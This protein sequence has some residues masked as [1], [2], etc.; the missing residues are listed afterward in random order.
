MTCW[1]YIGIAATVD[2]MAIK[3]AYASQLKRY[4]PEDDPEGFKALRI[5]LEEAL[6]QAKYLHVDETLVF[7]AN[8][9]PLDENHPDKE[10][11][12]R[13][14]PQQTV[15]QLNNP[16]ANSAN[17]VFEELR[18]Q[19]VHL[20]GNFDQRIQL[21]NWQAIIGCD[22]LWDLEVKQ[23]TALWLF[24]FIG[25]YPFITGEVFDYLDAQFSWR[26]S[27]VFLKRNFHDDLIDNVFDRFSRHGWGLSYQDIHFSEPTQ[28][29]EVESYLS[30]RE[31]LEYLVINKQDENSAAL[32]E[33][34]NKNNVKDP[35]L[36][37][38]MSVF[39]LNQQ[40]LSQAFTC[41]EKF[42]QDYPDR[43]E[44]HLSHAIIC[45]KRKQ[46]S[47]AMKGFRAVLLLDDSHSIALK[48]LAGCYLVLD[49][50]FSAKCLYEQ[51]NILFPFDVE[52]RIQLIQINQQLIKQSQINLISVPNN[53][54]DLRQIAE[55]Y[56][57]IGAYKECI[58]FLEAIIRRTKPIFESFYR[59][60]KGSIISVLFKWIFVPHIDQVFS[61]RN[62]DL[63]HI[64]GLAYEAIG[65][66]DNAV[67]AYSTALRMADKEGSNGYESLVKLA[68]LKIEQD[69]EQAALP[70][71]AKAL[72]FN[73]N[74]ANT[75]MLLANAQ[76]Y[77]SLTDE[78]MTSINRAI[79][80]NN[81]Q[82]YYYSI[83]SIL[84]IDAEEYKAAADDLDKVLT[85]KPSFGGAW[86]RQ[87]ICHKA[88]GL[89]H[90]AMS[91][92]KAAISY[93]IDMRIAGL[94]WL[95]LACEMSDVDN[96]QLAMAAYL[97][98]GG[99]LEAVLEYQ[100]AIDEMSNKGS[101]NH[102]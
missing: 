58:E 3:R 50:L 41:S 15:T 20:Y 83:R 13:A 88:L 65:Q 18:E 2:K 16:A 77:L 75:Y 97:N 89:H 37:R 90:E 48:G 78:A 98:A 67:A 69:E 81:Q 24:D 92:F 38:L 62:S 93:S 102:E 17:K 49:D 56:L 12:T 54:Q 64:L 74:D 99:E 79:L 73:P 45:Y 19:I 46:F 53:A 26:N 27:Y 47:A 59:L 6:E 71:L 14:N 96:A 30:R 68:E 4:H 1:E 40:D 72:A 32:L 43:I 80:L 85:A 28:T 100:A 63:H 25:H 11:I 101:G 35:E 39:Y 87:G 66:L 94:E 55:S 5:A 31:H 86:H 95:K 9:A 33:D 57:E 84:L 61:Y 8:E 22:D 23:G 42:Y 44:A 60:I 7:V 36:L 29:N 76:R 70:L 52:A 82:W 91:D 34:L 51:V 21:T 10:S